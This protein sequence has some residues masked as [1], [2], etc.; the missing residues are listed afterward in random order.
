[1]LEINSKSP[2]FIALDENKNQIDFNDYLGK[3]AI[4]LFFYPK[5]HTPGC[6]KET[7]E[8]DSNLKNFGKL[9]TLVCGISKDSIKRQKSFADKFDIS[10]DLLSDENG[11]TCEDF[12]VWVKKSM[13][14]RTF[15][16]IERSTFIIGKNMKVL[17]EWRKVKVK[18]HVS[19]V[20]AF[21]KSL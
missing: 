4:V 9:N 13:Y 20:I 11:K 10:L 19:E 2:S 6:T 15:F 14:G 18:D 16:G 12:G 1:M 3:K 7:L 21:L 5:N 17:K 8:F